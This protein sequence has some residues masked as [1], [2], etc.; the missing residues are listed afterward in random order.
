MR[1]HEVSFFAASRL[2]LAF[3]LSSA[4]SKRDKTAGTQPQ[5]HL[6]G[7]FVGVGSGGGGGPEDEQNKEVTSVSSSFLMSLLASDKGELSFVP[8]VSDGSDFDTSSAILVVVV[9]VTE[10]CAFI[11]ATAFDSCRGVRSFGE[12]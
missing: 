8:C 2:S 4:I 7:C 10:L 9:V 6:T 3:F 1:D 12:S 11:S 5:A